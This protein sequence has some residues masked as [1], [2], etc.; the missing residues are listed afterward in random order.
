[1]EWKIIRIILDLH[2]NRMTYVTDLITSVLDVN[3]CVLTEI[4]LE[5]WEGISHMKTE[6][7][8]LRKCDQV[9]SAKRKTLWRFQ[10]VYFLAAIGD[11][12]VMTAG[13]WVSSG[14]WRRKQ[15]ESEGAE[16]AGASPAEKIL[17]C[18][19]I[20]L[21]CPSLWKGTTENRVGTAESLPSSLTMRLSE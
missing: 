7:K 8:F 10:P 16:N 9:V 1:M 19:Y 18:P 11:V 3:N 4:G 21:W 13:W 6:C 5:V 2:N 14:Q 15:F 12:H 20:F 17:M